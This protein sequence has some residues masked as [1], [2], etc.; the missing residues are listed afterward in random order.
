[1]T[2]DGD[3]FVGPIGQRCQMVRHVLHKACFAAASR[4]FEQHW[5]TGFVGCFE[6]TD[7]VADRQVI[8]SSMRVQM[9]H[10]RAFAASLE[11]SVESFEFN[12]HVT[13]VLCKTVLSVPRF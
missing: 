4:S 11:A 6:N 3:Q 7:L 13:S 1:M 9:A 10:F 8:G 12:R 5:E 2:G